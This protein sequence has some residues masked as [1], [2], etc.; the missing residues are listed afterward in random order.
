MMPH[1]LV[2]VTSCLFALILTPFAL[3][4][5]CRIGALDKPGG[6][7]IHK[8]PKPLLGGLAVFLAFWLSVAIFLPFLGGGRELLG[9]F[10]GTTIILVLGI[11]DDLKRLSY[12]IKFAGQAL[13]VLVVL[14]F[15]IRIQF[16]N[17]PF[18]GTIFLGAFVIPLTVLWLVGV[19]N[20]V[21]LIDGVDGLASG[22]AAINAVVIAYLT[23]GE[24]PL[25]TFMALALAGAVLGFLPYNFS[26]AKIF[27]GDAGSL[28]LGFTLA[29]LAIMGLTKQVT[30]TTLLVPVLVLG[31]PIADTLFAILRRLKNK[32]PVFQ[33]DRG[34]LHHKLLDWGLSTRQTVLL[35]YLSSGYFGLSAI[36]V[37]RL[38][39]FYWA[40]LPLLAGFVLLNFRQD[41]RPQTQRNTLDR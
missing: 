7:K 14:L 23:W 3:R 37:D 41:S 5:A 36:L 10:F 16:L 21:N 13:A 2:G 12:K 11:V 4:L 15:N 38:E 27:L 19:T 24:I 6:R 18:Q 1:I 31:L 28:F 9:L 20:A 39:S 33:A 25:V 40:F 8:E 35:L 22:V 30:F 32:K 26:P 34:H 17:L 29:V